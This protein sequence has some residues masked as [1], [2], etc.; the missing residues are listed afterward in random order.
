MARSES[1]DL[2]AG[3]ANNDRRQATH[4]GKADPRSEIVDPPVRSN[5]AAA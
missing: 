5:A 2:K 3:I 4:H 1:H